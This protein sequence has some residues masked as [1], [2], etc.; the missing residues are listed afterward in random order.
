[1]SARG[2][3]GGSSQMHSM[4]AKKLEQDMIQ[5]L[6]VNMQA[7]EAMIEEEKMKQAQSHEK[8]SQTHL[9]TI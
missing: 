6:K 9:L 4:K 5:Q 1:M 2:T 8:V 3:P 7:Q